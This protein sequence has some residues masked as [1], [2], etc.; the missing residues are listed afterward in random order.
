MPRLS[1]AS[2]TTDFM[3]L[4]ESNDPALPVQTEDAETRDEG[5]VMED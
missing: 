2:L 4:D 3:E 5:V 1:E